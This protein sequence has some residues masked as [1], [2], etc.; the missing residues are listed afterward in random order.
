MILT[1]A[2][3]EAA[4]NIQ[5]LAQGLQALALLGRADNA[6]PVGKLMI[7]NLAISG[8]G[9]NIRLSTLCPIKL[10]RERQQQQGVVNAFRFLS[11]S[12]ETEPA[13]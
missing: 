3:S 2:T 7:E 4:T 9:L 1:A 13:K 11:P 5:K 10:L 8:E 6:D 12:A